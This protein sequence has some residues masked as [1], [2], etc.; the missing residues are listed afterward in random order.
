MIDKVKS[1]QR[2]SDAVYFLVAQ[3]LPSVRLFITA[4]MVRL[5][6]G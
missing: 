4:Y 6:R 2:K 3:E 1:D 5:K